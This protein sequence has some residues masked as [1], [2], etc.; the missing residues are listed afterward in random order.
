MPRPANAKPIKASV[1]S[2]ITEANSADLVCLQ[3]RNTPI[4]G[5]FVRSIR[6]LASLML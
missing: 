5:V 3:K 1:S 6:S 2:M 4:R